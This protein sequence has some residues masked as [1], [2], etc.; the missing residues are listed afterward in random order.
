MWPDRRLLDLFGIARPIVQ[1]P[2]VGPCTPA[3]AA[4]VSEAGDLG[5]LG[6]GALDDAAA[7]E[8]AGALK[9]LTNRP[10]NLNLF[11]HAAPGPDAA[12]KF[13]A[14]KA[15]TA[16]WRER[17]GAAAPPAP[18]PAGPGFDDA[19]LALLLDLRPAVASFHFGPPPEHAVRA[20]ESA[21]I[22]LIASATTVAEARALEAAGMD[23][24]I[25]QGW[26]AG[27]HRG[28]FHPN[29]ATDGVGLFALVPQV[30]DA[31]SVPVI[32]AGA[33][34]DGR[35][36]AAALALGASGVQM[37]T[38]FLRTPEAATEP[39]RRAALAAATDA[40]TMPTDAVSGRTA[41]ARRSP[42]ADAMAGRP[43]A[44]FPQR[45]AL[46]RPILEADPEAASFPLYGQ[47][48]PLGRDAPAAELVAALTAEARAAI[49]RLASPPQST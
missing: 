18:P 10:F 37:G 40:D 25:A 33:V 12:A 23:A 21:G 34:M 43:V 13:E 3:L 1:A 15:A 31:V 14:A 4:A 11:A 44:A 30:A 48:A 24:I 49:S 8:R 7:R 16:T 6:L 26:E 35:G 27:G 36:I 45:Y 2:M 39:R 29:G 5:S 22:R 42:Y 41:R 17:T 9:A 32:A 20:L 46:A 38:A 28:S 47:G 19:R